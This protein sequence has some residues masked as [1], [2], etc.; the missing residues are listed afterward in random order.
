MVKDSGLTPASTS[1]AKASPRKSPRKRALRPAEDEVPTPLSPVRNAKLVEPSEKHVPSLTL[2]NRQISSGPTS[3]EV[4]HGKVDTEPETERD[5][6]ERV[7][8][9]LKDMTPLKN[10]SMIGQ[11]AQPR[12]VSQTA[13]LSSTKAGKAVETFLKVD[14]GDKALPLEGPAEDEQELGGRQR[15]VRKS[16]NYKEPNLHV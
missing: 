3:K 13:D 6:T 9:V 4:T 11:R 10:Q 5:S 15:R 8:K 14:N 2:A 7:E 16:V 12:I 1:S